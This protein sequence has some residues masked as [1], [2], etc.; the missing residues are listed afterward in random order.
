MA[1]PQHS[2]S[3]KDHEQSATRAAAQA[4]AGNLVPVSGDVCLLL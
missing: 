4:A 1:T 2:V 3:V